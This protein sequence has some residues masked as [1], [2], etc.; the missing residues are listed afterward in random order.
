MN[1]AIDSTSGGS[2]TTTPLPGAGASEI[3][4]KTIALHA[5]IFI[6]AFLIILSRRPDAVLNAQFFAED[7]R[8]WYPDAYR[9]GIRSLLIPESGYLHTLTRLIALLAQFFPFA[10]A[11]LV[12]NLCA[13]AAQIAPV[14][15][16][17]SSRFAGIS[18]PARYLASFVYLALPNSYEIDANITTIQWH[19]ALLACLILLAGPAGGWLWRIF[20][21]MVLVLISVDGPMGIVL[22]PFAAVLGWKR[23]KFPRAMSVALL[24]PGAC[25]Q[26][27]TIVQSWHTRQ[28]AANGPTFSRFTKIVA[29]Q[30]FLPSLLGM[31]TMSALL[32]HSAV[33]VVEVVAVG[34]G[35]ALL[36]YTLRHGPVKLRLFVLFCAVVLAMCLAR[37]LAGTPD[38]PQW[39]WMC[40]PGADNRYYLLPMLA[41][42]ASLAWLAGDK[43]LSRPLCYMAIACLSLLPIGIYQDWRY[44]RFID[45]HF[46]QYAE[47]FER[48]PSGTTMTIPINPPSW[49]IRLTKK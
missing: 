19:L 37:P 22:I 46:R 39:E 48:A 34:L 10:L 47:Q 41:F 42:L 4:V 31:R 2:A 32:R 17:L 35:L 5:V 13:L 1:V 8:Q 18:L 49:S 23:L 27:L 14:N 33:R 16:F 30:V 26:V 38:R 12:M 45:Y 40:A 25:I 7:G 24:I 43:A 44:P 11:P 21:G 36:L 6:V 29:G 28:L 9:V 15:V 20:D 3:W